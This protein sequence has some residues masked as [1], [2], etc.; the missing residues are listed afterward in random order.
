VLNLRQKKAKGKPLEKHEKEFWNAN[1]KL[2]V[3]QAKLTE[4]EKEEKARLLAL[5]GD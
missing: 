2:C 3:L 1:K 4:E 5:L